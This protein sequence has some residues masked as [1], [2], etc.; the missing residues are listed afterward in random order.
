[1]EVHKRVFAMG[2][3][4]RVTTGLLTGNEFANTF[5]DKYFVS[6]LTIF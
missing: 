3:W 5:E 2:L 4:E 6:N 1:M